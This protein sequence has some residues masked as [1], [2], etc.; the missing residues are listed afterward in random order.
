MGGAHAGGAIE[1]AASQCHRR[2]PGWVPLGP[3]IV[4]FKLFYKCLRISRAELAQAL[5]PPEGGRYFDPCDLRDGKGSQIADQF[6]V[7]LTGIQFYEGR[8]VGE[9]AQRPSSTRRDN[10]VPVPA[11]VRAASD[12]KS[13]RLNS[14]H[15]NI[16]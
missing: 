2:E 3:E 14:S 12:R 16:S 13:I 5:L 9:N 4:G 7:R 10:G 6:V 8:R 15:A 11:F 1:E